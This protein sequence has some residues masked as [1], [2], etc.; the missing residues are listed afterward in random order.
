LALNLLYRTSMKTL[1]LI[2]TAL[3]ITL[4]ALTEAFGQ[5]TDVPEGT[6]IGSVQV[7]GFEFAKLS[8]GLQEQINKIVGTPLNRQELRELAARIEGEQ[9]RHVA[10]FRVSA[11]PDASA[12]IVFVVARMRDPEQQAN[13]NT[14]YIVEEVRTRGVSQSAIEKALIDDM[15]ALVGKPL[16]S[17][18]AER[19]ENRL[20]AAF[21]DYDVSH[22]TARG[23]EV[24]K[25][26]LIFELRRT[27][28]SRWL[29][30]EPIEANGTY[31][32]EQG[33]GMF[34]EIPIGGRDI[35]VTPLFAWDTTDDLLEEYDGLGI[36][37]EAR[38]LGTERLGLSLEGTWFNQEWRDQTIVASALNPTLPGLY[39]E[40]STFTPMLSFAITRNLRISGGV[41]ITEL[42]ALEALIPQPPPT[43]A[44]VGIG[45]IGYSFDHRERNGEPGH[46][47]EAAFTVRSGMSSLE[48]DYEYTRS[49]GQAE[50]RFKL[51]KHRVIVSGMGGVING[52]APM[53][54]RFALGDARTLRGWDKFQI[55]PVGGDQMFHTTVEY[56]WS[57]LQVFFDTGSVWNKGA[58]R[59][60][61]SS[62]GFG[63]ASDQAYLTLGIPLNTD[64]LSVSFMMGLRFKGPGFKKY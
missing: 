56:R 46:N 22:R 40:R 49:L 13:I 41:G 35:R 25:I 64:D 36:R 6:R 9:P 57:G 14:K 50:Y 3:I 28:R 8:P 10:A 61:R 31:H 12:R 18:Q 15:N 5:Q 47:V 23:S 11:D 17:E 39:S 16:D 33:W 45:S 53:F 52:E 51:K 7:S 20:R 21:P 54:E 24:G 59:Q 27:E 37:F 38:R 58:D 34:V 48:S 42:E 1:R 63:F 2:L 62:V 60:V 4:A 44:N 32:T 29:R 19:I 30:F 26:D 55:S 43:M